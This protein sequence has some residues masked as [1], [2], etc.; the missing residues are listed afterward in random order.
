MVGRSL[1]L[2]LFTCFTRVCCTKRMLLLKFR[3]W[4]DSDY[5]KFNNNDEYMLDA[6]NLMNPADYVSRTSC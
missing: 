5:F 6:Q 2:V 4:L 3:G 1:D